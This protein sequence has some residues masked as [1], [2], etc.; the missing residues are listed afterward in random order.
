MNQTHVSE[1]SA[2][3]VIDE[4]RKQFNENINLNL[5][6]FVSPNSPKQS[7]LDFLSASEK[8][9]RIIF[10]YQ[11][12]KILDMSNNIY[13]VF[14]LDREDFDVQIFLKALVPEHKLFPILA[15]QWSTHIHSLI[16]KT[17]RCINPKTCF[18]GFKIKS[19]EGNIR[20]LMCRMLYFDTLV[21]SK[22]R[23]AKAILTFDD[24]THLIKS[25]F[26]WARHSCGHN[27]EIIYH[28]NSVDIK[29]NRQDILTNREKE[30]LELI[31]KG[32]ESKQIA[33]QLYISAETVERHR[34][35]MIAR[36][37]ARDTTALMQLAKMTGII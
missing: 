13:D 4:L 32:L 37:G 26:W 23:H 35:N 11:D 27:N 22:N 36:T 6:E 31:S 8:S 14:G 19:R 2:N 3:Y 17:N 33:A 34:K 12:F 16:D 5:S 1:R 21:D 10:D 20:S 15:S 24:I 7:Y 28:T 18:C 30:V 9:L 29:H 25:D